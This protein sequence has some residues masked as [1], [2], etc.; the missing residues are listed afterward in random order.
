MQISPVGSSDFTLYTPRNWNSL[1]HSLIPLERMQSNFLE[2]KKIHAI[3]IFVL[4]STHYC[5]VD[6]RCG[7]KAY[8]RLLHDRRWG[9]RTPDT[10][11]MGPRSQQRAPQK[12]VSQGLDMIHIILYYNFT[13]DGLTM[14]FNR[15]QQTCTQTSVR[16]EFV[17]F[18]CVCCISD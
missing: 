15:I 1:F 3:P 10:Q 13:I 9:N 2:L 6:S 17:I 7:F 14:L 4:P 18:V 5:R 8:P 16:Q 11:I 12:Y